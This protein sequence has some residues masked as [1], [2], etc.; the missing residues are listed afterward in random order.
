MR[1]VTVQSE[2]GRSTV[3][4]ETQSSGTKAGFLIRLIVGLK[5]E[6]SRLGAES[7]KALPMIGL[8][9]GIVH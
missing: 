5:K 4:C 2:L 3:R 6:D 7:E 9:P 1:R 8:V